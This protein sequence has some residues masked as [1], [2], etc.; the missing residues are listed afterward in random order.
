MKSPL[1]QATLTARKYSAE[2]QN[3]KCFLL[4]L[5]S[6]RLSA[7]S[8]LSSTSLLPQVFPLESVSFFFLSIWSF[9]YLLNARNVVEREPEYVITR[10]IGIQHSWINTTNS[11][12]EIGVVFCS[13]GERWYNYSILCTVYTKSLGGLFLFG[14]VLMFFD[15]SL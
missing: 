6:F 10:A 12:T 3:G 13:A 7:S 11:Y 2:S 15:R 14:G 8:S 9:L 4:K 5:A 1:K